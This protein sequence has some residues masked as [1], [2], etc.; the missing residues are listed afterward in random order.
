MEFK[1]DEGCCTNTIECLWG[2]VKLKM[3]GALPSHLIYVLDEFMYR[4]RFGYENGNVY[5]RFLIDL[6]EFNLID[7]SV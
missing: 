7:M 6:F 5:S 1:S 3:K 2:L 4:Y